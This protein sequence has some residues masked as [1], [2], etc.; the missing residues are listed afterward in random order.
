MKALLLQLLL[1]LQDGKV[2][3]AEVAA[4]SKTLLSKLREFLLKKALV[5]VLAFLPGWITGP[6]GWFLT[7]A[8]NLTI[9]RTLKPLFNLVVLKMWRAVRKKVFKKE[10]RDLEESKTEE[11]F[12]DNFDSMS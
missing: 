1:I 12:D 5:K 10:G 6:A 9:N 8:I 7:V 3:A 11:D 4:L 2:K